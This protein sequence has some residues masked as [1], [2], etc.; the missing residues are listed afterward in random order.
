MIKPIL[1]S[2]AAF[3]S[4]FVGGLLAIR[5]KNK[6]HL[7]MGFAAGVIL[8]VV[9]FD[10]FPEIIEQIKKNDI[11]PIGIMLAL[12]SGFLI[13]HNAIKPSGVS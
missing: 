1:F 10:I 8:G 12:I 4:T 13:F 9:C 3:A 2:I 5:L 6:L 11:K 7:I